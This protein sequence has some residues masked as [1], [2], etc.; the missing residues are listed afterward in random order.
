MNKLKNDHTKKSKEVIKDI[1]KK[2]NHTPAIC[3]KNYLYTDLVEYSLTKSI[4]TKNPEK[5]F[6]DFLKKRC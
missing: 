6:V 4:N 5:Y 1:A 2:L 3:K